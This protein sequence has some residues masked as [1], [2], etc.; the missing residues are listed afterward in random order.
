QLRDVL[1]VARA[2][3][4]ESVEIDQPRRQQA[5]HVA[6]AQHP[7]QLTTADHRQVTKVRHREN[8]DGLGDARIL[9]DALWVFAHHF[10]DDHGDPPSR[11]ELMH[12]LGRQA[13][14]PLPQRSASTTRPCTMGLKSDSLCPTPGTRWTVAPRTSPA[15]STGMMTRSSSAMSA[16][17]GKSA[18]LEA[19]WRSFTSC[20]PPTRGA[21]RSGGGAKRAA[22]VPPC[23]VAMVTMRS[24]RAAP[25]S[26][27]TYQ[28]ATRPPRECPTKETFISAGT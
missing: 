15:L 2:Q 16:V 19:L 5:A 12:R 11:R 7:D 13:K 24:T 4:F 9:A 1:V 20:A 23:G 26:S 10:L 17:S 22:W 8:L 6:V 25:P 27:S 18:S 28:R 3:R 14:R 21:S